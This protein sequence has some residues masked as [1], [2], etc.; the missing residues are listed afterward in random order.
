MFK[1][2]WGK[3]PE[4]SKLDLLIDFIIRPEKLERKYNEEV[5]FQSKMEGNWK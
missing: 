2:L 4:E 5:K 3:V 1:Y